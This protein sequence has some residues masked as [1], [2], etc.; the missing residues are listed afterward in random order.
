MRQIRDQLSD[1]Y[2]KFPEAEKNDLEKIH[3]NCPLKQSG[4]THE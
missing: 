3:N 2:S 4:N 1:R